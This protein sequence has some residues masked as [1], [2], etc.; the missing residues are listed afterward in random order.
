MLVR[1]SPA[2]AAI[3]MISSAALAQGAKP[4]DPQIAHIAYTA[5]QLDIEGA[6]QA[7]SKSKNKDVR[8]FAEGES[9]YELCNRMSHRFSPSLPH[10]L[11]YQIS[12]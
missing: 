7:L 4:T 8:A 5:G 6:K 3:C 9:V 12:L 1:L 2:I 11:G 10:R